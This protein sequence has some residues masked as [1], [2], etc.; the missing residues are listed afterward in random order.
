MIIRVVFNSRF[1][2]DLAQ[3]ETFPFEFFPKR[4]LI[5]GVAPPSWRDG[6]I[7]ILDGIWTE[8]EAKLFSRQWHNSELRRIEVSDDF[9]AQL[10]IR[11]ISDPVPA[12]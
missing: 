3:I 7:H 4:S 6:E 8:A 10:G 1:H 2:R 9:A 12:T 5:D 11:P